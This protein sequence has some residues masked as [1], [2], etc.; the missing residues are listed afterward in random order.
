V[1]E[2]SAPDLTFFFILENEA[3][4]GFFFVR[5]DPQSQKVTPG[6]EPSGDFQL[7]SLVQSPQQ[8]AAEARWR[9]IIGHLDRGSRLER[10]H[11]SAGQ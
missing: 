4:K 9:N 1:Q 10:W 2:P 7:G 11:C 3:G 8:A 6:I 5:A